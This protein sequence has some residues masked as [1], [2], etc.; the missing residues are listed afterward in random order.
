MVFEFVGFCRYNCYLDAILYAINKKFNRF[1]LSDLI[2]IL[3][4]PVQFGVSCLGSYM[5]F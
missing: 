2:V 4:F 1:R 3:T 5:L